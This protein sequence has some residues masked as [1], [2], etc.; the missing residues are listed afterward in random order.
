MYPFFRL[1]KVVL[2]SL[3]RSK[4]AFHETS[5]ITFYCRP[6]DLDLFLEMNNGR[7]LTLYDLG[8]LDL[9]F[10]T[11][12]SGVLKRKRWGLAV[13]GGS[14]RYRHRVHVFDK[15]T[16][17]TQCVGYDERW[18][19]LAQSMWVGDKATS[20]GLL[21]TCITEKGK[22]VSTDRIMTELGAEDWKPDLPFWVNEWTDADDHR[23]W[24]P[25]QEEYL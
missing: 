2:Q 20:S 24:P 3:R 7:V 17:K 23:P 22:A 9:A 21:R 13:A 25:R 15:V 4:L 1:T 8:R 12:L 10:R 6:W 19:Y 18:I 16:I 5:E 14:N 11:G